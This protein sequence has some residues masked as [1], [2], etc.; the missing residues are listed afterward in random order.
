MA[1]PRIL[2][3]LASYVVVGVIVALAV[4]WLAPSLLT[5]ERPVVQIRQAPKETPAAPAPASYAPAVTK[6]A[7][8]IVNV[9]T[10]K[11]VRA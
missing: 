3:F 1:K 9:Y 5:S 11:E 6:A 4:V 2:R 10:T 7:P 8:A